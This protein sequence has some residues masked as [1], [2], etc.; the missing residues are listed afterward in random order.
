MNNIC[1]LKCI[2]FFELN[3]KSVISNIVKLV[4]GFLFIYV[5]VINP[6]MQNT[7]IPNAQ[8]TI[9]SLI[10][11]KVDPHYSEE[12]VHILSSRDLKKNGKYEFSV[13][14]NKYTVVDK[15]SYLKVSKK[16]TII[17]NSENPSECIV[18]YNYW[19]VL[20]ITLLGVFLILHVFFSNPIN[21]YLDLMLRA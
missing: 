12:E 4:V 14:G 1:K 2:N 5:G 20:H 16:N 21:K 3:K 10:D 15:Q 6:Y 18:K 11:T 13:D 17:Y 9:G 8:T 19:R 7:S